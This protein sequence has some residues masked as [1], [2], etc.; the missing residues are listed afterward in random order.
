[1]AEVANEEGQSC[2]LYCTPV[3]LH[4]VEQIAD[5]MDQKAAKQ[6]EIH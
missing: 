4:L 2:H 6:I 3:K 1:M 5:L